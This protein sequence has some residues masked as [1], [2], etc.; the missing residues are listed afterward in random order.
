MKGLGGHWEV[1]GGDKGDKV[2]RETEV[3][4]VLGVVKGVLFV[5]VYL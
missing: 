1:G 5:D 3:L 4:F 2:V